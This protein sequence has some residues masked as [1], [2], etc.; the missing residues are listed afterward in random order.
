MADRPHRL[1]DDDQ[2]LFNLREKKHELFIPASAKA[3]ADIIGSCWNL[4]DFDRPTFHQLSHLFN[5][6]QQALVTEK[7]GQYQAIV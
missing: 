4:N 3:F 1:L 7:S 6:H 2:V 5:Q